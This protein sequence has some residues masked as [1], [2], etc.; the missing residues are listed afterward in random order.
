[1]EI[2]DEM[3]GKILLL[4][5]MAEDDGIA[6]ELSREIRDGLSVDSSQGQCCG[7]CGG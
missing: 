2:S 6:V 4:C 3:K 7:L 1:M 5:S